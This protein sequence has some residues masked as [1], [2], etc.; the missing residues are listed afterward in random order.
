MAKAVKKKRR[1]YKWWLGGIFAFLIGA[2]TLIVWWAEKAG[3]PCYETSS[4]Q[5]TTDPTTP[6]VSSRNRPIEEQDAPQRADKTTANSERYL[7]R[8]IAPANLPTIYLVLIGIG[9]VLAAVFTLE[10]MSQQARSMRYQTTHLKNSV[11]QATEAAKAARDNIALVIGKER[12]RVRIDF[13]EL[14]LVDMDV[15]DGPFPRKGNLLTFK[16]VCYGPTAAFVI[17]SYT[18]IALTTSDDIGNMSMLRRPM[19]LPN[20]LSE[21]L[22]RIEQGEPI[23]PEIDSAIGLPLESGKVSSF[24]HFIATVKYSDV[25]Q[26]GKQWHATSY[27][28][29]R[30]I[31]HD[32]KSRFLS[33]TDCAHTD[34]EEETDLQNP[35]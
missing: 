27:W 31:Y 29:W 30:I 10:V 15:H 8:L 17:D 21:S 14:D 3:G 23:D 6:E 1:L 33:Y 19:S 32:G 11:V 5:T 16:V 35:N 9:G 20:Q 25:F 28:V 34:T 4:S 24:L 18:Q 13:V 2:L 22:G 12:A 26:T 7:C